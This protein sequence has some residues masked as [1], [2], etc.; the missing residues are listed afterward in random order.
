M[1]SPSFDVVVLGDANPDLILTGGGVVPQFGQAESIVDSAAFSLGGSG[2]I[3]AA[4]LARLGLRTAMVGVVGDDAMGE[5][6]TR[7]L[8]DAGV[9]VSHMEVSSSLATGIS[10]HLVDGDD[11]AIVTHIGAMDA[12]EAGRVPP[13]LLQSARH[14]HASS[15]FLLQRLRPG[16]AALLTIAQEAGA[17]TSVDTNWD[18][19]ERWEI[20]D[21]LRHV[22]V[23]LPNDQE[24]GP[25]AGCPTGEGATVKLLEQVRLVA[26]KKGSAGALVERRGH[27]SCHVAAPSMSGMVDAIGAGDS[28]NAGFLRG[29]LSKLSVGESLRLGVACGSLSV[30][31]A[32]GVGA[33][34]TLDEAMELAG[35]LS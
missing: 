31:A 26:V 9:D 5:L 2:A 3:T 7:Q 8:A 28:F 32:G 24:V 22:D 4:G 10:V 35:R 25:L 17:T 23:L 27:R 30:R 33:Q 12:L 15:V 11:R 34:P 16:L 20:G 19:T 6:T 29:F 14:V 1:S 21:L 18:P 13:S